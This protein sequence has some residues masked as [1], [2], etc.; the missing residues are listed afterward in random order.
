MLLVLVG[1]PYNNGK[2]SAASL[3]FLLGIF[4][5]NSWM[6]NTLVDDELFEDGYFFNLSSGDIIEVSWDSP[7]D[8]LT[9]TDVL[10]CISSQAESGGSQNKV[11]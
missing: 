3:L 5:N 9:T 1:L 4:M 8:T 6:F 11:L 7:Q 10:S 2:S